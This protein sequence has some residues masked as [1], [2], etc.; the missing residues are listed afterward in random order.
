MRHHP[1][2]LLRRRRR[3]DDA[4]RHDIQ[5]RER[6]NV[7]GLAPAVVYVEEAQPGPV[8]HE[9]RAVRE[10]E[11]VGVVFEVPGEPLGE[12]VRQPRLGVPDDADDV[13]EL[14]RSDPA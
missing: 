6:Y 14:G 11:L 1:S 13:D 7:E 8:R 4:D 12:L 5:V 2:P 10:A 9:E 3:H